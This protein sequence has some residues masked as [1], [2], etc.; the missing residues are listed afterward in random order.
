MEA[1]QK[2]Y[3]EGFDAGYSEAEQE[4][5]DRKETLEDN[6]PY[7]ILAKIQEKS[8]ITFLYGGY[9]NTKDAYEAIIKLVG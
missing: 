5:Y 3:E 2:G 4:Y 8:G 6:I 7:D 9:I 1:Y